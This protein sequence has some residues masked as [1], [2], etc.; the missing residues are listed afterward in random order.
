[1]SHTPQSGCDHRGF[2]Q[3]ARRIFANGTIHYCVQCQRCKHVCKMPEHGN[4]PW[5]K[6]SEIP[7][8]RT[9]VEFLQ[10]DYT[11]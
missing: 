6:H 3:Y 4:R 8:G 7:T 5:I 10:G 2:R 9:I 1:M 11:V